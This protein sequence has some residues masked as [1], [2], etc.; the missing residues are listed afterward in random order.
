M[1]TG[2]YQDA[3]LAFKR[4]LIRAALVR[5]NGNQTQA[6]EALGIRRTYLYRLMRVV[7]IK[8]S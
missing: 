5:S 7:G 8:E 4:D 6:A 1:P 3:V 2:S